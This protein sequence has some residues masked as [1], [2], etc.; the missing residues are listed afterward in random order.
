MQWLWLFFEQKYLKITLKQWYSA[1]IIIIIFLSIA[2]KTFIVKENIT[3]M[4]SV[5][6][7]H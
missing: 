2:M 1:I 7:T 6:L 3:V 5:S 4:L